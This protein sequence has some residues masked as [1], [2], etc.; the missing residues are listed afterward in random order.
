M[1]LRAPSLRAV[2]TAVS[3]TPE[4]LRGERFNTLSHAAALV[5]SL[6]GGVHLLVRTVEGGHASKVV[7]AAVFVAV[8]VLLYAAS[9]LY[10]GTSGRCKRAWQ[11]ADHASIFLL[12][13]GT[14]TPFA[15]SEAAAPWQ[16]T[17]FAAVWLMALSG[18]VR[19]WR[20]ADGTAPSLA[21]YLAM[22]WL[23]VL[24]AVPIAAG[25]AGA[26]LAW[27]LIGGLCYSAGTIWYRNPKG[28][29]HAHGI[30]HLFVFAGTACHLVAIHTLL[31]PAQT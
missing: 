23:G 15:L 4:P 1:S 17:M 20:S 21:R 18:V 12:I 19:E 28:R 27:L 10:H 16:Q 26:T 9:V 30:W 11:R 13:A 14:C 25:H 8:M 31:I 22:G 29:P 6:A 3:L 24:A 7:G 5:L 2:Q